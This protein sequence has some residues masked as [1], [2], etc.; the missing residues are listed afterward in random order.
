VPVRPISSNW[1]EK[2]QTIYFAVLGLTGD[3][4]SSPT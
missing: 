4:I 3:D 1:K 2:F